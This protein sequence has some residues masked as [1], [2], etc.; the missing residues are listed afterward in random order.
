MLTYPYRFSTCFPHLNRRKLKLEASAP[1]GL[2]SAV[3][4]NATAWN[5]TPRPPTRP[6]AAVQSMP[7]AKALSAKDV[8]YARDLANY[9]AQYKVFSQ[10]M[11][12]MT[13]ECNALAKSRDNMQK[14]INKIPDPAV[15]KVYKSTL[16]SIAAK[17][18]SSQTQL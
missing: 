17:L 5:S 14:L 8:T 4:P 1:K 2:P 11:E 15:K 18:A 10:K 6:A 9:E 12:A 13:K 7:A 3:K 16:E